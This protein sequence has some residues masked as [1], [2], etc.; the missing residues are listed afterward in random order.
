MVKTKTKTNENGMIEANVE[1]IL[2][3]D[4]VF[5]LFLSFLI[6]AK[7]YWGESKI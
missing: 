1:T 7:E 2:Y 3:A 5:I 6:V 4:I